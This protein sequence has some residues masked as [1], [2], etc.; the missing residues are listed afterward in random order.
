MG[1]L[2][3]AAPSLAADDA[4]AVSTALVFDGTS[5]QNVQALQFGQ[6]VPTGS[7]GAVTINADTGS[8]STIGEVV[9]LGSNQTRARF[10]LEVPI[11]FTMIISGDPSVVLTRAG[12]TETMTASLIHRPTSGLAAVTVFG[13]PIGLVATAPTQEIHTGGSLVVAGNQADGFYEGTFTLMVAYL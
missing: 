3:V 7:G 2:S 4:I 8:V 1:A 13:L 11:G 9:A 5:L 10:T 12:G 6:I